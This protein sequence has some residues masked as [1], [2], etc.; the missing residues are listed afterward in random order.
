MTQAQASAEYAF[1]A[2]RGSAISEYAYHEEALCGLYAHVMG[3]PITVGG[4]VFF[5]LNNARARLTII[6]K[7]LRK[8]TGASYTTFWASLKK[9]LKQLDERRNQIVH[10][11]TVVTHHDKPVVSLVP[12]EHWNADENTPSLLEKDLIDFGAQCH[13][14]CNVLCFFVYHLEGQPYVTKEWTDVFQQQVVYPPPADHPLS[15]RPTTVA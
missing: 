4:V 2:A 14:Y 6:D 5:Q 13:F 9:Q 12:P 3:V 10:W 7:L 8:K 11:T 1:C 15:G